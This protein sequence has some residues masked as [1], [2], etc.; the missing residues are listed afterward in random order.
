MF[1][2]QQNGAKRATFSSLTSPIRTTQEVQLFN[3]LLPLHTKG[4]KTNWDS[5]ARDFNT[6]LAHSVSSN[7]MGTGL[8]PKTGRQLAKFDRV[9]AQQVCKGNTLEVL[10]GLQAAGSNQPKPLPPSVQNVLDAVQHLTAA[11][12]A[13][14]PPAPAMPTKPKY[15]SKAKDNKGSRQGEGKKTCGG[16]GWGAQEGGIGLYEHRKTCAAYQAKQKAKK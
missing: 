11:G 12:Q 5:M 1:I 4:S 8:A 10:F 13:Q 3:H 7:S 9:V 15:A 2:R 6:E 16:C 14:V